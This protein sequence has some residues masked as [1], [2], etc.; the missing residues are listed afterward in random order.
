VSNICDA[1]FFIERDQALVQAHYA[2]KL[3]LSQIA[4]QL[5]LSV[6]RVSRIVSAQRALMPGSA[7]ALQPE[8]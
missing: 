4:R 1:E 7:S 3:S 6:S 5:G 8:L 2:S